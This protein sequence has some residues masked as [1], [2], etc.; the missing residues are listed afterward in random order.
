M[1]N[2]GIRIA[3]RSNFS[4]NAP[5][6]ERDDLSNLGQISDIHV[7]SKYGLVPPDWRIKRD[8]LYH[9]QKY[10]WSCYENYVDRVPMM[11]ALLIVGD[12]VEGTVQLRAEPRG[13]ISDDEVDQLDGCEETL[14]PLC[15]KAG[16]V[17]FVSGTPFHDAT[18]GRIEAVAARLKEKGINVVAWAGRRHAGQVLHLQWNGLMVNASHHNTRG[19]MWLAGSASR[20]AVLSAANEAARKTPRA[21]VII[22]GDLH[23]HLIL[24]T[25]GKWVCYLPG[26]TMPNPHAIRKMEATRAYLATDIGGAC[27]T[28]D[29]KLGIGWVDGLTYPLCESKVTVA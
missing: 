18:G 19:W 1:P 5:V 10:L 12:I 9:V 28:Y 6:T 7:L 17:Y 26:W 27:M 15:R 14:L 11:D 25:L 3:G 20:L 29:E 13:H 4:P 23:T 22:R 16:A 2:A 21:D 8:P 24:K